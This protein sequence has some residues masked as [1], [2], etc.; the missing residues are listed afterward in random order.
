MKGKH[1]LPGNFFHYL[2]HRYFEC[3]YGGPAAPLDR[4]LGTF[5]DGSP[6]TQEKMQEKW[7]KGR[8]SYGSFDA[9]IP[10]DD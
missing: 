7:R 2:H 9:P 5:H 8:R 10:A 6:E 4:W 1:T 3:N